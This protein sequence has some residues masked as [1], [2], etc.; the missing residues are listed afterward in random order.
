MSN[1]RH[2]DTTSYFHP[3]LLASASKAN[4]EAFFHPVAKALQP[5]QFNV[6]KASSTD[7][8]V[9]SRKE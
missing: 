3:R 9:A 5:A 4:L 1:S 8:L 6:S 7:W 2:P